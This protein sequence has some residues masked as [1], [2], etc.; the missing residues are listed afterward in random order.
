MSPPPEQGAVYG[1]VQGLTEFLPISSSGHLVLLPWMFGWEDPGLAFDVALHLGTLLAVLW[2]F[3]ADWARLVAAAA[4]ELPRGT[5]TRDEQALLFWKI[6]VASIPAV[7]AGFFLEELAST[8][9]RDPR[10]IAAMLA[11]FGVLLGLSDRLPER[12]RRNGT[13][14]WGEALLI[15][16]AQAIA[17]VPGV[18]RSGSTI[19]A[20]RA[21]AIDR[22]TAARFSFLLSTPI[23]AGA[24]LFKANE[25]VG[26][27]TE[28]G[29][30]LAIL[31]SGVSG[32]AA[33]AGLIR[34]VR[35]RSYFPFVVYRILLAVAI[36]ALLDDGR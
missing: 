2:Y 27:A 28:P 34:F 13:I 33:I 21:L 22:E 14:G 35:T 24:A 6:G 1:L 19:T 20:A 36:V 31:V 9:F 32:F 23:V 17:I 30:L 4:R 26:A 10:L 25:F 18:S 11:G 15:G 5:A 8:A 3:G 7:L 29:V 12:P 16:A